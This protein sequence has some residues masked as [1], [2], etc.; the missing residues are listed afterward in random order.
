M[1]RVTKVRGRTAFACVVLVLTTVTTTAAAG[2]GT[3]EAGAAAQGTTAQGTT[4]Q[5]TTAQGSRAQGTTAQGTTAQ[6]TTAQ[7]STAQGSTA[8][9]GQ[10]ARLTGPVQ[11]GVAA[12][13]L[14]GAAGP[15]LTAA[16]YVQRE[17]FASGTAYS[18][19]ATGPENE[20][21]TWKVAPAAGAPYRTR[22]VV[23]TPSNPSRF[24]GTVVVEWLNV[25]GGGDGAVDS[26]YLSPELERA[27]FAWVGV[28]AQTVG[29]DHLRQED[30]A[31]YASLADPGDQ[32]SFDIYTQ[33]ARALRVGGPSSPLAPLHPKRLLAVGES[34][35][36]IFLTTYIDAIQPLYRV[37]DGFLVHSRSGGAIPI[38]GGAPSGG[39]LGGAVRI[40]TDIG[41]PVLM[42]ITETDE[43]FGQY[44]RA[45]Q[46]DDRFIRLWDVAGASHADSYIVAPSEFR[47]L[48]CT[49][50]DDA[51]SHF[52]FEAAL[53]A[54]NRWVQSG[55]PPPPAPRMDV[56]DV[57]GMSTVQDNVSGSAIGGI[58]GPWER[59]PVAAYSGKAPAGAPGFCV[60]F[61]STNPF[62]AAQL[63]AKYAS[64]AHYLEAYTK[65]MDEDIAAGY[66]LAADRTQVRAFADEVQF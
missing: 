20:A 12:E 9:G 1:R 17:Y 56:Q 10:P 22:I 14:G 53:S 52:V 8:Q 21:G 24:N 16:G 36:A 26:V 7:G 59:V 62:T 54:L 49:S 61:G 28:S 41:V 57:H 48:G 19:R 51:P 55:T 58:E 25:S 63:R 50:I 64:K 15:A 6:G 34:Q 33:A 18:Y 4:A 65:A 39:I 23:R 35:S 29:I 42:M 47:S 5:G 13:L 45:R 2:Q 44:Y 27:G 38:P 66:L 43:T 60:L 11:P 31:R 40:R 32:F 46:P 37:F 30:P 3:A